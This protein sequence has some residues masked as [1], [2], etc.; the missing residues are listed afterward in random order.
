MP[1]AYHKRPPFVS[2]AFDIAAGVL[3]WACGVPIVSTP[4]AGDCPELARRERAGVVLRGSG[5]DALSAAA[6]EMRALLRDPDLPVRCRRVAVGRL[7]LAEVVLPRYQAN[8]EGLF[9]S[10]AA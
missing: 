3:T 4:D 6:E 7:G 2:T 10:A 5:Q 8:Y 1:L 9:G